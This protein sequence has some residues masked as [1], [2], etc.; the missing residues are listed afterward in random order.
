MGIADSPLRDR[1]IFVQGAPRSGTTALVALL[2]AHPQIG[3]VQSE[4]Y[5]FDFGV[6]RLSDNFEGRHPSLHGLRSYVERREQLV[7][8]ARDLC[9]GVLMSMRSHVGVGEEPALV[10]EKTRQ[11]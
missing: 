9:A 8:L 2:A 1:V 4:S 10:V 5:L 6:D 7:D 11:A 3:G